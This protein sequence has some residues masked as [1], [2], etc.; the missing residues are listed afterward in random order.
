MAA[1]QHRGNRVLSGTHAVLWW[2]GERIFECKKIE[3]KVAANREDVQIGLDI[4]SKM[5]GLKAEGTITMIKV[6]SRYERFR[7]AWNRGEDLRSQLIT[8]L[9]DPDAVGKQEERYSIENVWFN[10]LP[11]VSAETGGIIEEEVGFGCTAS[12]IQNLDQI[13]PA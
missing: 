4:D 8:K 6:Y 3:V 7:Q 9:A 12:D 13:S 2:D 1:K 10:E 5:T 11:L